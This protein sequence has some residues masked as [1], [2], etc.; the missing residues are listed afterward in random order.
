[1]YDAQH[2]DQGKTWLQLLYAKVK[3]GDTH[4]IGSIGEKSYQ[5]CGGAGLLRKST[6]CAPES[7]DPLLHSLRQTINGGDLSLPLN[8]HL[9]F[10]FGLALLPLDRWREFG[11]G[12][13]ATHWFDANSHHRLFAPESVASGLG[14]PYL[15]FAGAVGCWPE[16][17]VLDG[18]GYI[19]MDDLARSG[20]DATDLQR[21]TALHFSGPN[22]PALPS[23]AASYSPGAV[24][25]LAMR[26]LHQN[27]E[28]RKLSGAEMYGLYFEPTPPPA[29][30]MACDI[31]CYE[32][33]RV[34]CTGEDGWANKCTRP[35]CIGC[36][37]CLPPSPPLSPPPS[38][39]PSPPPPPPSYPPLVSVQSVLAS[40][41]T[42][43]MEEKN[44]TVGKLSAAIADATE[45]GS[46]SV[47]V[48]YQ[49]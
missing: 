23:L 35:L 19:G 18:L 24:T 42:A 44:V 13:R 25:E 3:Y 47:S 38:L 34:W 49:G 37:E 26:H 6:P 39:P 45:T 30:P 11:L 15:I 8:E 46:T 32:C 21:A 31:W 2:D 22:K 14:L 48:I 10:N 28:R 27:G 17:T 4:F 9:A 5:P 41:S 43:A 29:A 1:M 33:T 16:H 20:V 7:L 40:F 36:P 12:T